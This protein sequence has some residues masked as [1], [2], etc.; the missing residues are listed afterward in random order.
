LLRVGHLRRGSDTALPPAPA[1]RWANA[2]GIG[3]A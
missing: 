1:Q 2:A 3:M